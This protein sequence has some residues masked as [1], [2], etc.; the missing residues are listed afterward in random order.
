MKNTVFILALFASALSCAC[1]QA[2]GQELAPNDNN[3]IKNDIKAKLLC[4]EKEIIKEG[5]DS[6]GNALARTE[7]KLINETIILDFKKSQFYRCEDCKNPAKMTKLDGEKY[8]IGDPVVAMLRLS[9]KDRM[10]VRWEFDKPSLKLISYVTYVSN[11][12][13]REQIMKR[14]KTGTEIH[15]YQC[16]IISVY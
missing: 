8:I 3:L 15:K 5:F 10:L 13:E 9:T 6:S 4:E 1:S 11:I 12:P 14:A 7:N 2:S 16:S